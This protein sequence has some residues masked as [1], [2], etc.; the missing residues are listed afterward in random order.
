MR[1]H[2]CAADGEPV[3][4][5]SAPVAAVALFENRHSFEIQY[6]YP[7]GRPGYETVVCDA[8]GYAKNGLKAPGSILPPNSRVFVFRTPEML[9]PPSVPYWSVVESGGCKRTDPA[10]KTYCVRLRELR[11]WFDEHDS[12]T[13]GIGPKL[14]HAPPESGSTMAVVDVGVRQASESKPDETPMFWTQDIRELGL[15]SF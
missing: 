8:R 11:V 4:I 3:E 6:S 7:A 12:A 1:V 2:V 13:D 15:D 14:L 9:Q 5:V 10:G